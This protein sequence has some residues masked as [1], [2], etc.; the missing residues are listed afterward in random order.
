MFNVPASIRNSHQAALIDEAVI[1]FVANLCARPAVPWQ[2]GKPVAV[3]E[4]TQNACFPVTV[5]VHA[6][7]LR[8]QYSQVWSDGT[9]S[10]LLGK[11]TFV[12]H[13]ERL[14]EVA[15][16]AFILIDGNGR[17]SLK[18]DRDLQW[19]FID[20]QEGINADARLGVA[21]LI[22]ENVQQSLEVAPQG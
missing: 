17:F 11:L 21:Q 4:A 15:S 3:F 8:A 14:E 9:K 6:K 5:L 22:L 20:G 10:G 2:N 7:R 16:F 1:N 18:Q 12:E 13:N 19:R